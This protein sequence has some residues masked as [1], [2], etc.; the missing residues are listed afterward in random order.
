MA[1]K[2]TVKKKTGAASIKTVGEERKYPAPFVPCPHC[3]GKIHARTS[4]HDCGWV[5]AKKAAPK[6]VKAD[7]KSP[8]KASKAVSA[9]DDRITAVCDAVKIIEKLGGL[10][11]AKNFVET[12]LKLV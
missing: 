7:P 5:K 2:K 8:K 10:E 6:A 11:A 9:A 1:K 4:S 3:G 12:Y